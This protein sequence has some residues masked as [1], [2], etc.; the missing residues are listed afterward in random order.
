M[1]MRIVNII[2]I[3]MITIPF[4]NSK[5]IERI[6]REYENKKFK[7]NNKKNIIFIFTLYI[8]Q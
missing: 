8:W 5:W 2:I 6:K 7:N 4:L 3:I 1:F